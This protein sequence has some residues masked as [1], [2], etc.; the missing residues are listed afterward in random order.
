MLVLL[1]MLQ[2]MLRDIDQL[3]GQIQDKKD[4]LAGLAV[5]AL[6]NYLQVLRLA[7][8]QNIKYRVFSLWYSHKDDCDVSGCLQGPMEELTSEKGAIPVHG[9]ADMFYQLA[10]CMGTSPVNRCYNTKAK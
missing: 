5:S 10:A 1:T 6:S 9:F 4:S 8:D 7:Q 2:L 3:K